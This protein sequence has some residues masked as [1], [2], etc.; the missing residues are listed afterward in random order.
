[1]KIAVLHWWT[2]SVGGIN[3]TLQS[4]RAI[5]D[6][7]GDTFHVFSSDCYRTKKPQV[8]FKRKRIRGG[9]SFIMIDGEAPYHTSNMLTSLRMLKKYDVVMTSFLCP[10]ETKKY[11]S[12]PLFLPFLQ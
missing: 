8:Y 2:S 12:E 11:G 7:R 3:T 4:L 6:H 5:A 1:M 10:R 9:D